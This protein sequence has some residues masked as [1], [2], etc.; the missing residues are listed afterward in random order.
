MAMW[1]FSLITDAVVKFLASWPS[2][3]CPFAG[4]V[5]LLWK[6]EGWLVVIQN[7]GWKTLFLSNSFII[8]NK[9]GGGGGAETPPAPPPPLLCFHMMGCS[10]PFYGIYVDMFSTSVQTMWNNMGKQKLVFIQHPVGQCHLG[11]LG[12]NFALGPLFIYSNRLKNN[13]TQFLQSWG[14]MAFTFIESGFWNTKAK[15]TNVQQFIHWLYLIFKL[16]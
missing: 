8:F 6:W 2:F 16:K 9:S 11:G 1:Q 14:S 7:G 3:T 5:E 12:S 4:T 15:K 10:A 13:C